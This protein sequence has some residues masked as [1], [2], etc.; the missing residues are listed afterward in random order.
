MKTNKSIIIPAVIL[1]LAACAKAELPVENVQ[2]FTSGLTF[3]ASISD[4]AQSKAY[5]QNTDGEKHNLVWSG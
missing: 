4:S 1:S 5:F 2:D 3:S